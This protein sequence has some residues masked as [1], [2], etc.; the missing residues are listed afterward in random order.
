V[1][2]HRLLEGRERT[3][4][5]HIGR[6]GAGD[7][8]KDQGRQPASER[9]DGAGECHHDEQQPVPAATPEAVAVACNQHGDE[10]GAGEQRGEHDPDRGVGEAPVG[11]REPDQD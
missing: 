7:A 5:D 11:E 1:R 10:R 6:D 3:R 4:L 8:G 9:E 2:E